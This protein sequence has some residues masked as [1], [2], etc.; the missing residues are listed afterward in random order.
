MASPY[1][2]S[3]RLTEKLVCASLHGAGAP[4]HAS[5]RLALHID[6]VDASFFLAICHKV[7]YN[8]IRKAV[9]M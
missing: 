6:E 4:L 3:L 5:Q 1:E 2:A 9:G 7:C 8:D